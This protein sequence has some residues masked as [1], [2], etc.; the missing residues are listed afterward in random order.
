MPTQKL[1]YIYIVYFIVVYKT[2][3]FTPT[4]RSITG[5]FI[6]PGDKTAT[7]TKK[8]QVAVLSP[9]LN[10]Y[11]PVRIIP[12]H[13][14]IIGDMIHSPESRRSSKRAWIGLDFPVPC[15][16]DDFNSFLIYY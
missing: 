4:F 14:I 10:F 12:I 1:P 7:G 5:V 3:V 16:Y 6:D 9:V 15:T 2:R 13:F 8:I 11:F